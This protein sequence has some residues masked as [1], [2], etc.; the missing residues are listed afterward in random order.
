[1]PTLSL[2]QHCLQGRNHLLSTAFKPSRP[3]FFCLLPCTCFQQANPDPRHSYTLDCSPPCLAHAGSSSQKAPQ[4]VFFF[5]SPHLSSASLICPSGSVYPPHHL[6]A[7]LP[8]PCFKAMPSNQALIPPVGSLEDISCL[9]AEI[10]L[11]FAHCPK[12]RS[13]RISVRINS[14]GKTLKMQA[15]EP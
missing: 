1:M 9:A 3:D 11:R 5:P 13:S 8:S 10:H 15:A 6:C 2:P 12:T 4:A 7:P 14:P